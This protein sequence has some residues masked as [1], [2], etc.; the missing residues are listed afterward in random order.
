MGP[1]RFHLVATW[2]HQGLLANRKLRKMNGAEPASLSGL[3]APG[4]G[5]GFV[6]RAGAIDARKLSDRL[7]TNESRSGNSRVLPAGG[8]LCAAS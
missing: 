3:L 1:H 4:S 8:A 6:D 5:S 7:V 2:E